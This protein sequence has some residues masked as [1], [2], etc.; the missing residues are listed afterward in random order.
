MPLILAFYCIVGG[1]GP[2]PDFRHDLFTKMINS[3]L[4]GR[5][6]DDTTTASPTTG[7]LHRSA[8][9]LG[10]VRSVRSSR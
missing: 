9:G 8:P 2:L 7:Q 10:L 1:T 4:F 5:W 3:M 6:R